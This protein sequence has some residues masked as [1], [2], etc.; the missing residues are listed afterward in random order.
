[1]YV[2]AKVD[3]NKCNGCKLC[4]WSCPDPNIIVYL[5]NKKVMINHERCKGCGLC[6]TACKREALQINTG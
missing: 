4:I 1:M 2:T 3:E 6:V 5:P